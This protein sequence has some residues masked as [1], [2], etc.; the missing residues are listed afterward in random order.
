M[1]QISDLK[2]FYPS[3]FVFET[4]DTGRFFPSI[5]VVPLRWDIWQSRAARVGDRCQ[6]S[7]KTTVKAVSACLYPDMFLSA[8][9]FCF[10]QISCLTNSSQLPTFTGVSSCCIFLSEEHSASHTGF[11]Q[12]WN[13]MWLFSNSSSCHWFSQGKLKIHAHGAAEKPVI[14]T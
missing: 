10:P 9:K 4:L 2:D 6:F 5:F 8:S 1:N 13:V 7:W 14:A 12:M 3:V 11:R